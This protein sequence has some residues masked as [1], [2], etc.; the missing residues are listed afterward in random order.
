MDLLAHYSSV[1]GDLILKS[2][3]ISLTAICF[4][5]R[6]YSR[7]RLPDPLQEETAIR[8]TKRWL[9]IYFS[10]KDPGFLPPLRIEGTLFQKRVWELLSEIPYGQT[11][12]YKEIAEVLAAEKGIQKMSAQA[13]GGA[14]GKNPIPIIVP[15]HR[16]VG[17]DGSLT[18]YAGG[19][20]RKKILLKLEGILH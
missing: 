12:S 11:R 13:V 15:C 1:L 19:I 8:E 16:I 3:G 17:S 4:S 18:G 10:G 7:E 14:V 6:E 9:D 2:D 20:E 5:D